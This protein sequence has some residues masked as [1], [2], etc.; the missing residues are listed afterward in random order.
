MGRG[1]SEHCETDSPFSVTGG[2]LT[3]PFSMT[4]FHSTR[5]CKGFNQFIRRSPVT[6]LFPLAPL[7]PPPG[8]GG[9]EGRRPQRAPPSQLQSPST[10]HTHCQQLLFLGCPVSASS[11]T[12][13]L[14]P[15]DVSCL[16]NTPC[17]RLK[18]YSL[19]PGDYF[20][21]KL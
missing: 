5:Q 18:N 15:E 2:D 20:W 9:P 7:P 19:S 8:V 13:A 1:R 17:V 16:P 11:Q 10:G 4:L 12:L 3:A 21:F 14:L 6:R